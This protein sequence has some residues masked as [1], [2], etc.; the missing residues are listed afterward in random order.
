MLEDA[1]LDQAASNAFW[2]A[3]LHEGQICMATGRILA[4]ES[5]AGELV[6]RLAEKARTITV[7]NAA[8]G[9]AVLGPLINKRQLQR[10][11]EIVTDSLSAGATLEAGGSLNSSSIN[12]RF[13]QACAWACVRSTRRSSV[14]WPRW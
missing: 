3:W 8:R 6:R 9:E 12:L 4:H 1:D 5:I 10:V 13:F 2:G 14:R 7:G 11:H